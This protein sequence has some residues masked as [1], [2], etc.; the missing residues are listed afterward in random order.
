MMHVG[1]RWSKSNGWIYYFVTLISSYC[2]CLKLV[3]FLCVFKYERDICSHTI[4][5]LIHDFKCSKIIFDQKLFK[6]GTLIHLLI[7][8]CCVVSRSGYFGAKTNG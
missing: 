8:C 3:L 2:L 7:M 4:R 1:V 6:S 5:D